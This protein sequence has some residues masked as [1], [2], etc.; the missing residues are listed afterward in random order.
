M[1][2]TAAGRR[3][4]RTRFIVPVSASATLAAVSTSASGSVSATTL[5]PLRPSAGSI[6]AAC[7]IIASPAM[8][9]A[10]FSR[11]RTLPTVGNIAATATATA[12]VIL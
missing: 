9:F 1:A 4:R 8:K 10:A 11:T 6:T 12:E 5:I 7:G 3:C 2:I